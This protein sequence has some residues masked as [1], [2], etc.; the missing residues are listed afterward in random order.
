MSGVIEAISDVL[1]GVLCMYVCMVGVNKALT[2]SL[3]YLILCT[4][5]AV[6]GHVKHSPGQVSYVPVE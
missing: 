2:K 3:D 1:H 4:L 5:R 6:R